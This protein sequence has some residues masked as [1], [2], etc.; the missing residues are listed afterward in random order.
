MKQLKEDMKKTGDSFE[1]LVESE[2]NEAIKK[3]EEL[4]AN[5]EKQLGA[6]EAKI[7]AQGSKVEAETQQALDQ[8][9][10]EQKR[11]Q[12]DLDEL[13]SVTADKWEE[14]KADIEK[15]MKEFNNRVKEVFNSDE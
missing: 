1:A 11:L 6:Y 4:I 8:L 7:K 2:K 13:K 10:K 5:F 3:G 14:M 15:D 9:K 12:N